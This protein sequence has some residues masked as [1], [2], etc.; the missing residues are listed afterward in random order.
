MD[1]V[2]HLLRKKYDKSC[3][4]LELGNKKY[5]ELVH[6]I[7]ITYY[8]IQISGVL[9]QIPGF[10]FTLLHMTGFWLIICSFVYENLLIIALP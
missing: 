7:D 9:F 10:G 4:S 3:V 2:S 5:G 1:T 6:K 8:V